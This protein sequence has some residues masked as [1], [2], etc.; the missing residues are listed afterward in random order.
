MQSVPLDGKLILS[1]R[2]PLD[3]SISAL[4]GGPTIVGW[5]TGRKWT[6]DA[7]QKLTKAASV[8]G[9]DPM[10]RPVAELCTHM[11]RVRHVS[12]SMLDTKLEEARQLK[13]VGDSQGGGKVDVLSLLV[14]ASMDDQSSYRMSTDM[15]QAQVLTFL[16]A[17]HETTAS[18]MAWALWELA[19]DQRVQKKLRAECQELLMRN[20]QP[21]H[22]DASYYSATQRKFKADPTLYPL[23]D[24]A[25]QVP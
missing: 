7:L 12:A 16:A 2:L 11:Y 4:P 23:A 15:I 3:R 20:D 14:K 5:L 19:K 25:T 22:Q 8:V 18:S 6:G 1:S 13:K 21:E 9:L 10:L 24:Q 17:G